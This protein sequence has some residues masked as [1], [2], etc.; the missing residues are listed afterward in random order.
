MSQ[1]KVNSIVPVGGLPSGANGGIIQVVQTYK[2]DTFSSS[3]GVG[4]ET[5]DVT[6]LTATIT[7]SS[8]SSKILVFLD[9]NMG[10]D[11]SNSGNRVA[12]TLYRGGSKLDASTGDASG[13]TIRVTAQGATSNNEKSDGINSCFLDSPATTSAITYSVRLRHGRGATC[14]VFINRPGTMYDYNYGHKC[15][16]SIT[17]ME[18]TT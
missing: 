4:A 12:A 9:L 8:N 10:L 3:I 17:L 18:V 13:S 15:G 16:S 6:G 14:N 2:T 1:I 7:P 11:N 5:G